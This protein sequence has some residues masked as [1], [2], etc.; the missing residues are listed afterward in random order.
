M[1]VHKADFNS[2]FQIKTICG[3]YPSKEFKITIENY[4]VTCKRC[5]KIIHNSTRVD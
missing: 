2:S 3:I 4:K 5:K 1:K